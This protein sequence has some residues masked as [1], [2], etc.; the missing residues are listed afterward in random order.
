MDF[1]QTRMSI[2]ISV[3]KTYPLFWMDLILL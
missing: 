2:N 1:R 3:I